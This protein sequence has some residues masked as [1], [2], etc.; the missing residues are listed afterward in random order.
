[1]PTFTKASEVLAWIEDEY[2]SELVLRKVSPRPG[3]SSAKKLPKDRVVSLEWGL[4]TGE[5]MLTTYPVRAEGVSS[6]TI[7]GAWEKN[8][9]LQILA[10]E[11]R[12][13]GLTLTLAAPGTLTLVCE[14]LSIE[15]GPQRRW[16][17][18]PRIDPDR[19]LVW[20]EREVTWD[21]LLGWLEPPPGLELY[22]QR[23]REA[24][25]LLTPEERAAVVRAPCFDV[26]RLQANA[27]D[28]VPALFVSWKLAVTRV[29]HY[30]NVTRGTAD[31]LLWARAQQLPAQLGPTS[32]I[33][34]TVRTTGE[35]WL[36]RWLMPAG[37]AR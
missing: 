1:M 32:I 7:D 12:K 26:F 11:D 8:H 24:H 21:E 18:P 13:A 9:E 6:W 31:D 20:G 29:G 28:E 25:R 4:V 34:G 30:F 19:F 16:S 23:H 2:L 36:G 33:S 14:R 35:E 10:V 27:T 5:P 3:A 17:P 22:E 15:R 37:A